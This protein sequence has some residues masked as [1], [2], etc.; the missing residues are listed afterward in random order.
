MHSSKWVV[1]VCVGVGACTESVLFSPEQ[2]LGDLLA[3]VRSYTHGGKADPRVPWVLALFP[4]ESATTPW[5][6]ASCLVVRPQ[7]FLSSGDGIG[8]LLDSL[9]YL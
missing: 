7:D 5:G 4:S 8:N 3:M 1:F 2:L 6:A 9:P